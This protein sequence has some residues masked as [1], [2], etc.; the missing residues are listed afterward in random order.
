MPNECSEWNKHR[1]FLLETVAMESVK[2]G[3]SIIVSAVSKWCT[4]SSSLECHLWRYSASDPILQAGF[5]M[6]Y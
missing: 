5:W 2:H 1:L 3:S 4:Q 6:V